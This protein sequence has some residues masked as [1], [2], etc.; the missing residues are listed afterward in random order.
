[1]GRDAHRGCGGAAGATARVA[2]GA[3]RRIQRGRTPGATV[4]RATRSPRPLA[5]LLVADLTSLWAGPLCG[6]LLSRAGAVVV[7]VE[8]PS[9]PDGT[10]GGDPAFFDWMNGG[11]LCYSVDFDRDG[12]RLAALL[13]AADVVLGGIAARC[14]D[15]PWSG[16]IGQSAHPGR[17]WL[18]I[19]GYGTDAGSA[20]RVAFGDD[21]A[22]AGGLVG[23]DGAGPVF[24]GDAIADPL[25]GLEAA[26]AVC[27]SV[28]RGGGEMIE[29]AMAAV[30]ASYAAQPDEPD[31]P[32]VVTD[33]C[34]RLCVR[35]PPHW[36]PTPRRS[37]GSSLTDRRRKAQR[38]MLI[39]RAS[40]LD[41]AVVDLRVGPTI[42]AVAERLTPE[43]CEEMYDARGGT[44]L[45]GLH[46]HHVHLWSSAAALES[47]AAGPPQV[48]T[49][50]NSGM[51]CTPRRL[52]PTVGS[53]PS[54]ITTVSPARLIVTGW[55]TS[56]RRCPSACS[57]AAVRCGR[58]NSAALAR[59]G[60][61]DHP[62]GR[63]FREDPAVPRVKARRCGS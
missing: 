34:C 62:D 3:A 26:A 40:L 43:P 42:T 41:G 11:K 63:F 12:C 46:D 31:A 49:P 18:R 47:V 7:K 32:D 17:V 54:A 55:T 53:A 50:P 10:R 38:H 21:A 4:W 24:V 30:A 1:M 22:V 13:A 15:P 52:T 37:N 45:P 23:Y 14:V 16:P 20:E 57:T 8:S 28:G 59:I 58:L 36:A 51:P 5:G 44:V 61:A 56:R 35:L 29:V 19:T 2:R 25:T 9:R 6:Q 33:R 39:T 27:A 60:A 48:R